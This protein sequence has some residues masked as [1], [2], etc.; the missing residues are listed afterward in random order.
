MEYNMMAEV[1]ISALNFLEL[2]Q[3]MQ[4]FYLRHKHPERMAMHS[5][6]LSTIEHIRLQFV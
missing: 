2:S 6:F 5:Y 3:L 4:N 1:T